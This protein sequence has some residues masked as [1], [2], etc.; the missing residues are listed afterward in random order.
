MS[1]KLRLDETA[2]E[3]NKAPMLDD[4]KPEPLRSPLLDA[5][6]GIRHGYFT[7]RGGVSRGIYADLNIGT[8]S[9]D[10]QSLVRENRR[11]VAAWMGVRADRLRAG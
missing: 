8:G 5:A 9:A 1:R 4:A 6:A 7:R 2:P 3:D 10:D 11:L